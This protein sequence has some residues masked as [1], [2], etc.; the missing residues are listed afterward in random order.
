M[1]NY[2]Y[3]PLGGNRVGKYRLYFNLWLVF[4]ASG[5]WHGASWS[6]VLWGAYHGLF[7]VLERGFLLKLY[8]K[9][10]KIPSML[11]TFFVVVIGW[12]FFRIENI[13]DAFVFL[14]RL[15]VFESGNSSLF[16]SEFYFYL[17]IALIFSFITIFKFGK[18]WQDHI[19]FNEYTNKKHITVFVLT[20]VLLLFSIASITAFGF[21]P[22]I[23]FRF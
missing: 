16:D 6:F 3:I 13:A 4:L 20:L 19:Y 23:Y 7:L 11:I 8:E 1:R 17:V 10:G 21:N 9:I 2:L 18:K 15:F 14:K 22:F 12:V 5:L